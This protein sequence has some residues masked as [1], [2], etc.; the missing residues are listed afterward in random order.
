MKQLSNYDIISLKHFIEA[1]RDAG[2]KNITSA[3]AELID[4]AFEAEARTVIINIEKSKEDKLIVITSDDGCGMKPSVLRIALQFGGST[5]FNSRLNAGR[6]GMGLPNSSLSQA[7]R[8]EVITWKK[9][10]SVWRSYLDVD[11]IVSGK[12]KSVPAPQRTNQKFAKT[13]S[14]TIV[15]WTKCDRIE[16]KSEKPFLAKIRKLL[17]RLFRKHLWEG[18][19]I[20]VCGEK[21]LPID[22][23]F[24]RSVDSENAISFGSELEYKITIPDAQNKTSTVK[25][26]FVE[27]PIEK[28]HSL[29]NEQKQAKGISKGA[30]VSIIRAGREIDHG[31]FFMG[32]KRKE[33]YD[34]WWRCEICFEPELD[35]FFGVTNTK[36]GIRPKEILNGIL[37]PDIEQIAHMLN[38]RVRMRYATVKAEL[39]R[40]NGEKIATRRDH[41]LEPPQ[42]AFTMNN[43]L[44]PY[45]LH[46]AQSI[47]NEKNVLIHGL[48]YRIETKRIA[49]QSFFVPLLNEQEIIVLLNENHPFFQCIYSP[50]VRLSNQDTRLFY[51]HLELTL[52]A[53][54]RAECTVSPTDKQRVI[55]TMREEWS[56]VLATFLE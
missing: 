22:P 16:F 41:L 27:L 53:A 21:V 28:W 45:G 50:F 47:Y 56:K 25:V 49:E 2:Y 33:N 14:G 55:K 1:T 44:A 6:F 3:L 32:K 23:L 34:D 48:S 13:E 8:V 31:W 40:T 36:Q 18:K 46:A 9:P 20:F 10:N 37:S 12:L 19:K 15:V 17:G 54:A 30:G 26:Q 42:M 38:G 29:S 7:R 43:N 4:N 24:L 51:Q 35:E 39:E 11:E 52:L 5:R